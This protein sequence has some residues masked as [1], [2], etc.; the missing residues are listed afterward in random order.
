LHNAHFHFALRHHRISGSFS[1]SKLVAATRA[2]TAKKA[3]A[4]A[5]VYNVIGLLAFSGAFFRFFFG[6]PK[7]KHALSTFQSLF[8]VGCRTGVST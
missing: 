3:E 7:R 5:P 1:S 4:T 6:V 8:F 2:H